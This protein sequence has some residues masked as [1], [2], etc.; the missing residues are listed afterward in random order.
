ME[1]ELS[2]RILRHAVYAAGEFEQFT[3]HAAV[4]PCRAGNAVADGQNGA[5]LLCHGCGVHESTVSFSSGMTSPCV[6]AS[7]SSASLN[8]LRRPPA[9][10]S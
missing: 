9:L 3:G 10:Q 7:F 2:S 1:T 4:E 5:D 8:W 6:A